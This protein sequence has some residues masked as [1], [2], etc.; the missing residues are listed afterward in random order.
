MNEKDFIKLISSVSSVNQITIFSTL[1]LLVDKAK[2]FRIKQGDNCERP[3]TLEETLSFISI[4]LET[5]I[6]QIKEETKGLKDE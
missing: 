5:V 1:K 2:E 4:G 6:N 3:L